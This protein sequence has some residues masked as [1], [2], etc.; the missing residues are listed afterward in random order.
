MSRFT[1]AAA[2]YAPSQLSSWD[3]YV[4]KHRDWLERAAGAGASLAVFP[5][6]AAMELASLDPKT[7]GDLQASL[8]FVAG[9]RVKCDALLAELAAE[10]ALHIACPSGPVK[11]PDGGFTNRVQLVAPN[12]KAGFQ[13]KIV[14]TRFEREEWGI[15]GGSELVLFETSL[16]RIGITTCY[17]SEFPLIA[18]ALCDAGG[19]VLLAPSCTDAPH[20]YWRVR[21]GCAA[22][23]LEGQCLVVQSPLV[24]D[25]EWSPAIDVNRGAAGFYAPPDGAF[26]DDGVMASGEMD[27]AQWLFCEVDLA[28]FEALRR[29]GS[30][31]NRRDWRD[32]PGAGLLPGVRVCDLRD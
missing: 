7:M 16:G 15:S 4:A 17:D 6:Y 26:P 18:R 31:L 12:G 25:A 8:E 29:D 22:R 30:V 21:N 1:I 24:G 9:L 28:Q 11:G 20:G 14:M 32:Q 3:E 5:E 27:R 19:E 23:A 13:D 2:Q 10:Y